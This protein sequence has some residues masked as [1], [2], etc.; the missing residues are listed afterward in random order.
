MWFKR[1]FNPIG[2][3]GQDLS[4]ESIIVLQTKEPVDT[5]LAQRLQSFID[6][7]D[8]D[9]LVES[10]VLRRFLLTL[11]WGD[12]TQLFDAIVHKKKDTQGLTGVNIYSYFKPAGTPASVCLKRLCGAL[13]EAPIV[14][15]TTSMDVE[16]LICQLEEASIIGN[17]TSKEY[18]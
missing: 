7:V 2:K 6:K 13:K 10:P 8:V 16:Q 3:I 4:T 17:S 12:I 15:Y 11:Y 18:P 1:L 9:A 14:P 5:T